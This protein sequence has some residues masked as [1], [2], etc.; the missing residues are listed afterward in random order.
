MSKFFT[1]VNLPGEER[2]VILSAFEEKLLKLLPYFQDLPLFVE[3][4][5]FRQSF[6]EDI[7]IFEKDNLLSQNSCARSVAL[8]HLEIAL[9]RAN[10]D[11]KK[12][13]AE[14]IEHLDT[15][16]PSPMFNSNGF[17][18]YHHQLECQRAAK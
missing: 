18:D 2:G 15:I 8:K 14:A 10:S 5:Q 9:R 7:I 11:V 6:K 13:I 4:N 3:S 1:L 17:I 16:Q 12:D